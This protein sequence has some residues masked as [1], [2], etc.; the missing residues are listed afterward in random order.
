MNSHVGEAITHN[1]ERW[2]FW[3]KIWF[4]PEPLPLET[5]EEEVEYM[6]NWIQR[7]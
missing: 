6:K 7:E 1:F 3:D 4:E 5:H 2:E